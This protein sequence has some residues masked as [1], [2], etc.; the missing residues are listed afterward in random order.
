MMKPIKKSVYVTPEAVEVD[1][2]VHGLLCASTFKELE[3]YDFL[4]EQPW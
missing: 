2:T 4:D 1:I 3:N